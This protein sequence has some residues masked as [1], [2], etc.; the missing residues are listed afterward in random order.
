[1]L[2]HPLRPMNLSRRRLRSGSPIETL[3]ARTLLSKAVSGVFDVGHVPV[4]HPAND[5]LADVQ[6]GPLA[7]AGTQLA[8]L[9]LDSRRAAK[10]G[11]TFDAGTQQYKYLLTDGNRVGVTLRTRGDLRAFGHDLTNTYGF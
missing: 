3:E 11:A 8:N 4:Y 2:Q 1:M 5:N 7:N 9:Y 10:A 6:N